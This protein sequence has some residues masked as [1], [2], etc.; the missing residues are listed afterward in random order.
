MIDLSCFV[1]EV[2]DGKSSTKP[3]FFFEPRVFFAGEAVLT[4]VVV[5]RF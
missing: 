3:T 4:G 5:V 1:G 2:G